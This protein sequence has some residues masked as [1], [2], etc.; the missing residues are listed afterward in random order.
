V[1]TAQYANPKVDAVI[2]GDAT[3]GGVPRTFTS[4]D[5]NDLALAALD[6]AGYSA[7]VQDRVER[8]LRGS[9]RS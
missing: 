6:Q 9:S 1:K 2:Y 3:R 4:Q 8:I 5:Y 7:A